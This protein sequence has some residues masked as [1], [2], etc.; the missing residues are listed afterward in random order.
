M[1][2]WIAPQRKQVG[3]AA[4]D[5]G[6]QAQPHGFAKLL[7]SLLAMSREFARLPKMKT[8]HGLKLWLISI[9]LDSVPSLLL[10]P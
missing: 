4:Q 6:G 10:L 9:L 1:I 2:A 3:V 5:S 7:Q 8:G